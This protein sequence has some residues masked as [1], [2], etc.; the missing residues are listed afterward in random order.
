MKAEK[1][2]ACFADGFNCAQ[3]VLSSFSDD[4]AC[5]KEVALKIAGA[6]GSG[7][8]QL[9]ET[10]GAVTGALMVIGLKY[11]KYKIGDAESKDRAYACVKQFSD[12]FRLKFGSIKC[13]DL[14]KYDLSN[15][16]E[17][18]EARKAGVF[19]SICPELIKGSVEILES[20]I[21]K[22]DQQLL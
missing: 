12:A 15:P 10:C 13:T 11:G 3:A 19:Q 20:L 8:G 14:I 5:P 9:G 2:V 21:E 17:L 4:Y 16:E 22:N 6:F 18:I 7:M 1:A